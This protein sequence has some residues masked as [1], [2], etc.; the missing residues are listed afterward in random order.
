MS[1]KK[2]FYDVDVRKVDIGHIIVEADSREE[3]LL[4]IK[5]GEFIPVRQE[6][7]T[8]VNLEPLDAHP[9]SLVPERLRKEMEEEDDL[10]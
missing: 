4:K 7:W 10:S 2:K 8:S 3:A 6:F 1:K 9:T 5:D